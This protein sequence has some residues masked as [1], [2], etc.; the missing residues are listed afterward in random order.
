MHPLLLGA[1]SLAA[2]RSL[3]SAPLSHGKQGRVRSQSVRGK[4]VTSPTERGGSESEQRGKCKGAGESEGQVRLS[5]RSE[6]SQ[7]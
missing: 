7:E 5:L 1:G 3:Q 2:M 6:K 4:P